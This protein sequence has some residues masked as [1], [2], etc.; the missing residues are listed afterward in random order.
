MAHI[1]ASPRVFEGGAKGG[2]DTLRATEI[3]ALVAAGI[4]VAR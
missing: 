3:A 1:V 4:K 2:P